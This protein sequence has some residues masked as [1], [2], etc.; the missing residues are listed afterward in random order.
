MKDTDKNKKQ[1]SKDIDL[2]KAFNQ[3]ITASDQQLRAANQQL[4]ASENQLR[5]ANQQLVASKKVLQKEKELS[6]N[7]LETANAV[8]ITLDLDAKINLFNKYA[9]KL[10]GYTKDEILGRRWFDIFISKGND[11]EIPEV[12]S[13][14]LNGMPEV[15]S[16]ENPIVCKNGSERLIHW[17]NT[18]QKNER[19]EVSGV[20]SIGTDITERKQVEE[21]LIETEARYKTSFENSRDG[22]IV[23]RK[24][25]K[26]IAVNQEYIKLSGYT[27]EELLSMGL[28]D[29]YQEANM[30]QSDVRMNQMQLEKTLSLFDATLIAKQGNTIPVEINV[31]S[32]KDSYGYDVV[33]QGN[34]RDITERKQAEEALLESEEKYRMVIENQGEGIGIVDLD[35]KFVFTNPAAEQMFGVPEG[36]L[37]GHNLEEFLVPNQIPVVFEETKNRKQGVKSTYEIE[38]ISAI[39]ENRTLLITATPQSNNEGIHI[40][41]FGIFRDITKRKQAEEK[42]RRNLKEKN[43][44]LKELYHRT[45]NNMQVIS[46]MLRIQSHQSDDEF[47]HES[48]NDVVHKIQAMSLVHQKLYEAEDL[49]RINLKEYIEDM[50]GSLMQSCNI[51]TELFSYHLDLKDVFVTIDSA[52]PLGL[53]LNELISNVFKHSFPDDRKGKLTIKLEQEKN[54]DINLQLKDNG[55][56]LPSGFDPEKTESMGL[57]TVYSLM[58]YQLNGSID[59]DTKNGLSW[60]IK[61]SDAK[62]K[63]RV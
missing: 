7:I 35:E 34:V 54:G 24:D 13:K 23:F 37:I 46:S 44:L 49:S 20:L 9:E 4:I 52:T 12:F 31:T 43:T 16:Y 8:I 10:T 1:L 15:S 39:G 38:I 27:R 14:V 11:S 25:K 55:V 36:K 26:I 30:T 51:Q 18:I 5:A 60:F 41:T 58:V 56:G 29:L 59:Y 22:I 28:E 21:L 3:Q 2:L 63:L 50:I 48:F 40:G 42:I 47:V 57:Q 33:F 62:N 19:G 45:K 6:E 17:E 53:V 32:L 61:F